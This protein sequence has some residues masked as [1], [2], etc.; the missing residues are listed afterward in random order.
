[1]QRKNRKPVKKISER[2]RLAILLEDMQSDF[3]AFGEG[4]EVLDGKVER[5]FNESNRQFRGVEQRFNDVA[6]RFNEV[7]KDLYF[8]KTELALIRHDLKQKVDRAE[9]KLLEARVARLE[10]RR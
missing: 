9:F 10:S 8:I 7:D 2:D 5:G 4:L 6:R 3:R 1:M